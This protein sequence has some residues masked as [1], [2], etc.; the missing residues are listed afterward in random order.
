MCNY[1]FV[2]LYSTIPFHRCIYFSTIIRIMDMDRVISTTKTVLVYW[3]VLYY[4]WDPRYYYQYGYA[5]LPSGVWII[6]TT[7]LSSSGSFRWLWWN[8]SLGLAS[9]RIPSGTD[10]PSLL[11]IFSAKRS[12]WNAESGILPPKYGNTFSRNSWRFCCVKN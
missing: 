11:S 6:L 12:A 10:I 7:E 9:N 3:Y 4:R 8:D 5:H 1:F 2:L